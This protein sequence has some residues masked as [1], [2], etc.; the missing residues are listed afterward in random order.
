[1]AEALEVQP[2]LG[3]ESVWPERP[4]IVE[5]VAE[6][7]WLKTGKIVGKNPQLCRAVCIDLLVGELSLRQIAAR[8]HIG[9]GSIEAI[10]R[11]MKERGELEPLAKT[12]RAELGRAI[13]LGLWRWN[14]G[15]LD[16]T[17]HPGQTPI[18]TAAL[19]D[20]KAQLDAGIVPGTQRTVNEVTADDLA[21][22]LAKVR[23]HLKPV[24]DAPSDALPV[25]QGQ[26]AAV[27]TL[28][29]GMDTAEGPSE[30][31]LVPAASQAD[32]AGGGDRPPAGPPNGRALTSEICSP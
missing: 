20:K 21:A 28:D 15:L 30:G 25:K 11:V 2:W 16:G 3:D 29:T 14:E 24:C 26:I 12:V 4:D 5:M 31:V 22:A 7:R 10:E 17:V 23:G 6:K 9:R 13:I 19:I 32:Q 8:Y 1:M 27:S 18:P